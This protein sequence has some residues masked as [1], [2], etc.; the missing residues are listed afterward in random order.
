MTRTMTQNKRTSPGPETLE[1]SP[2]AKPKVAKV[3]GAY[4]G[5]YDYAEVSQ[6]ASP[7]NWGDAAHPRSVPVARGT[8]AAALDDVVII[9]FNDAD[10]ALAILDEIPRDG[11]E[12]V[13]L[14]IRR[15]RALQRKKDVPA[16][17][18]VLMELA[19]NA[20][21]RS[22]YPPTAADAFADAGG[23]ASI[24]LDGQSVRVFS[25]Q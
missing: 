4:H 17:T 3:E 11:D 15:A 12:T 22:V 2:P 19:A 24:P 14:Q 1:T 9:P 21:L 25:V 7:A 20:A 8:P 6:T 5:L 13:Q 18:A 16:A 10:A 23:R